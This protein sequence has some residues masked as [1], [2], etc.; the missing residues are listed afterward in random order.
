MKGASERGLEGEE[1]LAGRDVV[2]KKTIV[3]SSGATHNILHI[4]CQFWGP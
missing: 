3:V 1:Y 2:V 4:I